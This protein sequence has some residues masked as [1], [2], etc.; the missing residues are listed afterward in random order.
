MAGC[1]DLTLEN[2]GKGGVIDWFP[3]VIPGLRSAPE[4]IT[5]FKMIIRSAPKELEAQIEMGGVAG[6]IVG[7]GILVRT[8]ISG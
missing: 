7:V 1:I 8:T 6:Y 3:K 5:N 4:W 2:A